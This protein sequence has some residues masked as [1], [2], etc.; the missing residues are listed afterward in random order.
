[1]N[2]SELELD[3]KI[4]SETIPINGRCTLKKGNS[5]FV[6][7]VS[8]L[9][10]H[11]WAVSDRMAETYAMVS[12]IQC[13][14]A[15]QN[16]VARAFEYSV[17]TLRRKQRSFESEGL[18]GLNNSVGRPAGSK[19]I[20][21]PMAKTAKTLRHQGISVRD[22]ARRLCVSKSIVSKWTKYLDKKPVK[23]ISNDSET[24][25]NKRLRKTTN[26]SKVN[27]TLDKD[28]RSRDYDRML[29]RLGLLNDAAPIFASGRHIPWAGVLLAVPA[30]VQSGI[31]S[32]AD[33]VYGHIGPAFY[34]LRTTI[35]TLLLMSLLR[36]KRP[37]GLKEHA[38]YKLGRIIGLDRAP[39]VKTLRRKLIRLAAYEKA[40]VFGKQLAKKRVKQHGKALG[41]LYIDGHVRVY[42]GLRRL[43]KTYVTRMR[44]ALP[45]TTDY[46]VNDQCGDPLFVVTAELN[47]SLTKMLPELLKE[48]RALAGK[49]RVTIVFDRGGWSPKL[50]VKMIADGFDILTYRKGKWRRIPKKQFKI[51]TKRIE[52]RKISYN[53][54]DRN[55]RLLKGKLHLRQITRLS[56]NK[57]HQTA[58]VTSRT[59]LPAVV[60]AY[61]MFERWRQENFFKYLIEE[62]AIDAL[63]D[64]EVNPED[65][66]CLIPNP[67]R[68]KVNK[69]L[70]AAR[71]ELRKTQALYG[72]AVAESLERRRPTI[73]GFKIAHGELASRMRQLQ[74]R[75]KVIEAKRRQIPTRVAVKDVSGKQIVR[76]SRERKHITNCIKMVAYQAE[77]D[78]LALLRP[79]YARADQEGR[80]LITS[81]FQSAADIET[82]EDELRITLEP[83]S[84][85]HRSKAISA[86]C[87]ELNRMDVYFPGTRLLLRFGVAES[88]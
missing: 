5:L 30:L 9:P 4:R 22:I 39:E 6:V 18:S 26:A 64:Y 79:H 23:D 36:V 50:F 2:Q 40:E 29:A 47:A 69:K 8:G 14:Y 73:R 84:S 20:P 61:R 37:E 17:R 65:A 80:T 56:E 60:I 55:I 10:M 52:G 28:P 43:M 78:L 72:K 63:L 48:I 19:S 75:I 45:A 83:L 88:D 32:V 76:L 42:H 59:D 24:I 66:E 11:Q 34:G 58:I 1:M 15:D 3:V 87:E 7:Y 68:R 54:N 74:N 70:A 46:W 44:L 62:F 38:P 81:A 53:L 13:G 85:V 25:E 31:F 82:G 67:E 16:E 35:V 41:F 33:K 71:S 12:L 57:K 49:R 86:M 27:T 21:N 77:S 51:C